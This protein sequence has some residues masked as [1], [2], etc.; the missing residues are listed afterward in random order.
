[1]CSRKGL[2][3]LEALFLLLAAG[4]S[5][6]ITSLVVAEQSETCTPEEN[7]NQIQC[8]RELPADRYEVLEGEDVQLRCRVSHQRGKAQWRAGNFLLGK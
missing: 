8:L 4:N 5:S 1:M 2:L 3:L 7:S 6:V